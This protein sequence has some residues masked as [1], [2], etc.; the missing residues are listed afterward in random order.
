MMAWHQ[1]RLREHPLG[2]GSG[3]TEPEHGAHEC[4]AAETTDL[5]LVEQRAELTFVH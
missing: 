5:H 4:P 1:T 3:E 2:E